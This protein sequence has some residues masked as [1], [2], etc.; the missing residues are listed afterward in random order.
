[1]KSLGCPTDWLWFAQP[2]IYMLC[3]WLI[4]AQTRGTLHRGGIVLWLD[5]ETL[6]LF[7]THRLSINSYRDHRWGRSL[8]KGMKGAVLLQWM[9]WKG[10]ISP[11]HHTTFPT[12]CTFFPPHSCGGNPYSKVTALANAVW[13]H[14]RPWSCHRGPL[15]ASTGAPEL[16][17]DESK[18]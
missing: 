12:L 9:A 14:L 15:W 6:L 16:Q 13:D 2:W 11:S 4:N 3:W 17:S 8:A 7:I 10:S 18:A 5:E 1:M